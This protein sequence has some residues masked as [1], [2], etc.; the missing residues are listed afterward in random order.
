MCKGANAAGPRAK[1]Q[2]WEANKQC[3]NLN[4]VLNT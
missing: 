3:L 4:L 1:V 2:K